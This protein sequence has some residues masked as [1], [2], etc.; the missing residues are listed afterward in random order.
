MFYGGEVWEVGTTHDV[1]WTASG[2]SGTLTTAICTSSL[3]GTAPCVGRL[4]PVRAFEDRRF[5]AHRQTDQA[6]FHGILP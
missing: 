4:A 2:G 6:E 1:T 3:P 5:A